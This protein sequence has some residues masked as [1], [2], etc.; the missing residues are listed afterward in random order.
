MFSFIFERSF[1]YIFNSVQFLPTSQ[2]MHDCLIEDFIGIS[3]DYA[4][5]YRISTISTKDFAFI[6]CLIFKISSRIFLIRRRYLAFTLSFMN[7]SMSMRVYVGVCLF[8]NFVW[9]DLAVLKRLDFLQRFLCME[10][11]NMGYFVDEANHKVEGHL[12][13]GTTIT[14]TGLSLVL[15]RAD[16]FVRLQNRLG[17]QIFLVICI[18]ISSALDIGY[19]SKAG[20]PVRETTDAKKHLVTSTCATEKK[21]ENQFS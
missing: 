4:T 19:F 11:K 5:C 1:T 8:F 6:C 15:S 21:V 12:R 17:S 16:T 18:R 20:L 14:S 13:R 3:V 2:Q 9:M 7:R 10:C